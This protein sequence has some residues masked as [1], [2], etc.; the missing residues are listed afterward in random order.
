MS[1]QRKKRS[2]PQFYRSIYPSA[3]FSQ[4]ACN[5][6]LLFRII[7][8]IAQAAV[9]ISHMGRDTESRTGYNEAQP[10]NFIFWKTISTA[11]EARCQHDVSQR[12]LLN[13]QGLLAFVFDN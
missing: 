11:A 6:S 9:G 7:A 5:I 2:K 13:K 10:H 8:H 12:F 1:L 4:K 3:Y